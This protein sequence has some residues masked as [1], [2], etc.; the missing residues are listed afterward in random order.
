MGAGFSLAPPR[1]PAGTPGLSSRLP[2]S[3]SRIVSVTPSSTF[4]LSLSSKGTGPET[5]QSG[6]VW[7][8]NGLRVLPTWVRILVFTGCVTGVSLLTSLSLDFFIQDTG[9]TMLMVCVRAYVRGREAGGERRE[10]IKRENEMKLY[11]KGSYH[12]VHQAQS[13]F[14]RTISS[15]PSASLHGPGQL[16][17]RSSSSLQSSELWGGTTVRLTGLSPKPHVRC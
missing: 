9:T 4:T 10:Y 8:E 13:S 11:V 17:A 1:G 3:W 16:P 14:I 2:D 15:L 6:S 12:L 7:G 5:P